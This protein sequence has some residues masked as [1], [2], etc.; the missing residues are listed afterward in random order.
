MSVLGFVFLVARGT[1]R[2]AAG[3]FAIAVA[4]LA[5]LGAMA[6]SA[7][8]QDSS[9]FEL[10]LKGLE[11]RSIGPAAMGGRVA[12]FAVDEA[13]PSTFYVGTATGGLWKTT[14]HGASFEPLFDDQPTGSIGDVTL[15]PSNPE[16]VWVGTGEPQNRQSS[17]WGLGVFKSVDGGKKWAYIG[18]EATRHISRIRIHPTN[19]E[20][21]YVAAVGHLWGP[22]P[23]RG[24]YRTT[25]GGATWEKVLYVDEHTGAIDLAM[26][27]QDPRILYAAMYQRRRTNFGFNGG[28]PG[29]GIYR[30][31]D[32]GAT[33]QELTEGLPEGDMGRIGLDI[34]RGDPRIVYAIVEA[35]GD[36]EGIYRSADRG[37]TWEQVSETNPRPM[38][39]SQ[40]RIDPTDPQ[41]IYLG[42]TSFYISSD[43]GKT[44]EDYRFPGVHVDHH[45]IWIDPGDSDHLLL[46]NDG[47]VYVS[48]DRGAS[49][50]MYDNMALG[51]Y[52]EIGVDMSEP[53]N[54]CGGLQ[55]NGTWC[56]PNETYTTNG[57][58][59]GRWGEVN[60]G[61]GFYARIDPTDPSILFAESQNG[62][63]S[64]IDLAGHEDQSIRP[65]PKPEYEA[66]FESEE[67]AEL[68]FNWNSPLLLSHHDPSV[69]YYGSNLL[70]R[71]P[72][73]G[74]SWVQVSPDLTR[75]ID[76]DSL[77]IMGVKLAS[78]S[79][80]SRN[81]GISSFGNATTIAESPLDPAVLYVGTDDGNLQVTQDG[82]ATWTNVVERV[83]ELPRGTYVSRVVA[84]HHAAGRV[85][86]SFDGHY[87]DD[88]AAY[89]YVSED[90]GR[91]WRRITEGLPAWSVNVIAE[92]SADPELLFVGNEVG[93]YVT[94]DRGR[95]WTRMANLPTVPVDDIIVH[96]RDDD[97][98]LGT[99]GRSV[100]ILDDLAPLRAVTEELL[101]R[102]LLLFEL[103]DA[104]VRNLTSW[105]PRPAGAFAG[106]NPA[107][108]AVIRYWL[109]REVEEEPTITLTIL[110][111]EGQL[112]RE[113]EGPGTRGLHQVAWDL[114]TEPPYE[115]PEEERGGFFR[116]ARGIRVLP[117]TY[118]VRLDAGGATQSDELEVAWDPR[119]EVGRDEL[120][121]RWD[122]ARSVY[123]LVGPLYLANQQADTLN[124][125][126]AD[127]KRLVDG[128][129]DV[130]DDL[131]TDLDSL[132]ARVDTLDDELGDVNRDVRRLYSRIEGSSGRPTEDQL[133]Q[134][135]EAWD[136]APGLIERLNAII[137]DEMPAL[138]RRLDELGIRPDPGELV[139]VPRP[140][141]RR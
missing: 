22:N 128:R 110:D 75:R 107:R 57:I 83:P 29:S 104:V 117:G 136:E 40:I 76:R 106:T 88:Y 93:V 52:Y 70:F 132:R 137:E 82:G 54:V 99:H 50:R 30:T 11:F 27:P 141:G 90:T 85:Y 56:G 120:E 43:G 133:R 74:H 89:V 101:A 12:D 71:S 62:N 64:R 123:E 125:R 19:P 135:D 139:E 45:A 97:L 78:D 95:R 49:W 138:Y 6:S 41:R 69:V 25:D 113:L 129:D 79:I 13:D 16:I 20:I 108:G 26:D 37:A 100:W 10:F 31:R 1:A 73:R 94:T 131:V 114:R 61:D 105:E 36:A 91:R 55:D 87:N 119:V 84:S 58:L 38:Y 7:A 48:F 8:A 77:T 59:N 60:G 102:P 127:V 111:A 96:P 39:Y 124:R 68:R 17:P 63:L 4:A 47:G 134:L 14:N 81:D 118:T 72:D 80:L 23:E 5:G 112:V 46:G 33:W 115:P 121:V 21:V 35:M 86:A 44:F 67:E 109:G 51:Q 42:G 140:P 24:V 28:G 65:Q 15:A 9:P 103:G 53:Y 34:Y 92:H 32:G 130:P 122:A 66:Q 116:G 98:V 3:Q 2:R 18:L 126:L